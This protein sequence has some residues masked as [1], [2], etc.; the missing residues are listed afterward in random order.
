L[1]NTSPD[2]A[3]IVGYVS[4]FMQR[5]TTNHLLA[6]K[7]VLRHVAGTVHLGCVYK[8]KKEKLRLVGYN[9]NDLVGDVDTRK[10]TIEVMYFYGDNVIS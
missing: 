3:Y 9:D 1:V 8:S 10:S 7:S 6:V 4:Q 2:I 5:P